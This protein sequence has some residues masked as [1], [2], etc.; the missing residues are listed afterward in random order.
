MKKRRNRNRHIER[1]PWDDPMDD[2]WYC[3][4][5][6]DPTDCMPPRPPIDP[7]RVDEWI[8]AWDENRKH[9]PPDAGRILHF[10]LITPGPDGQ[11][12]VWHSPSRSELS[13]KLRGLTEP[14]FLRV[15]AEGAI[16]TFILN[17]GDVFE[18]MIEMNR[19]WVEATIKNMFEREQKTEEKT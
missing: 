7:V 18:A 2:S 16:L 17:V 11:N 3:P 10:E 9:L 12:R 1:E 13:K 8:S 6:D 4:G 15:I 14:G 19:D 5:C